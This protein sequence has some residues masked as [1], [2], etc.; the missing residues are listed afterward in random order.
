MSKI[1]IAR[2]LEDG[3]IEFWC[4]VCEEGIEPDFPIE[5][6]ALAK[7]GELFEQDHL[8]PFAGSDTKLIPYRCYSATEGVS[9]GSILVFAHGFQ[10]AR[11]MA[12]ASGYC[13]NV[14]DISDLSV[15]EIEDC[16][17]LPIE[18]IICLGDHALLAKGVEHIVEFPANCQQCL[19]WGCGVNGDGRCR[20][21]NGYIGDVA[22]AVIPIIIK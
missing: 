7:F 6:T 8:H 5:L 9:A 10:V 18:Q 16:D 1:V 17:D 22:S 11:Y 15:D 12:W 13:L 14:D 21:C 3:R 20:S 19:S 4:T 2:P